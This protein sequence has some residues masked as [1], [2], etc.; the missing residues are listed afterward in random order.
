MIKQ[1]TSFTDFPILKATA[2]KG[3]II[4][5]QD[6]YLHSYD[7]TSS[8]QS[9]ITVGIAADLLEL[10]PR[11]VKGNNYIRSAEISPTGSRLVLDFRGDIITVPAEKGDP[12]NIT[13]H[14][15]CS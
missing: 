15:R 2:G 3:K 9:K 1:L 11:F 5:E 14:H 7:L 12:R 4:F 10:R 8:T 6:G 13:T